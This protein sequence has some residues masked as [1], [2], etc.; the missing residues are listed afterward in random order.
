M[1]QSSTSW[2]S[3]QQTTKS[4]DQDHLSGIADPEYRHAIYS[5]RYHPIRH[6]LRFCV[7]QRPMVL[8]YSFDRVLSRYEF[9]KKHNFEW[10][11]Y[12][13]AITSSPKELETWLR[14]LEI[15]RRKS[16][17]LRDERVCVQK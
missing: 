1:E 5:W 16:Q 2:L 7:L 14:Q 9:F 10:K 17:F 13:R 11:D 3:S 8:A 12:A 6:M 4:Q 15:N